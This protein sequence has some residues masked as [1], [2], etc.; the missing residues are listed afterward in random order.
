[1]DEENKNTETVQS[2][3]APKQE[4]E[5]KRRRSLSDRLYVQL[6]ILER[7][8]E[9]IASGYEGSNNPKAARSEYL[10]FAKQITETVNTII[11]IKRG[12]K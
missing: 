1:M 10:A 2:T 11:T 9:K 6:E 7:E 8:Q 4:Q 12:G 5:K 3:E